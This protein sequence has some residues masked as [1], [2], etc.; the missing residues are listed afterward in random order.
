MQATCS[1]VLVAIFAGAGKGQAQQAFPA[2]PVRIVVPFSP[3]SQTDIVARLVGPK[4]NG[5]WG[6]PVIIENRAGGSGVAGANLVAK[7]EPD[8]HTILLTSSAFV[9]GAALQN[10]LPY[11]AI[12]DFSG[13][14]QI[15][16]TTGVLVVSPELGV[17]SVAELIQFARNH[18]TKLLAGSTGPGSSTFMNVELFRMAAGV[19]VTHV[20]FKGQPE[21]LV[22][23][24]GGRIH[25][26]VAG[27]GPALPFIKN[28]R[29]LALAV[30]T[31]VRSSVLPDIPAMAE[32]LAGYKKDG[33]YALLAP[34]RTPRAI[35]NRI[36]SDIGRVLDLADVREPLERIGFVPS[37]TSP[38]EHDRILRAQI[39]TFSGIVHQAGLRTP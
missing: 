39:D 8:G 27:L 21:F 31:P 5:I 11:D 18:S 24:L 19:Q 12:K 20:G 36:S 33:S 1:L 37:P 16:Y 13:V 25:I 26:A 22:E 2:K 32:I 9:I 3:G 10:H 30:G 14:T 4:L 38:E 29:L 23:I 15:G 6:Q 7:A 34:A 28:G 17:K 35:I